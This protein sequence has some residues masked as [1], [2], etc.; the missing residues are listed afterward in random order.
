MT[1][2]EYFSILPDQYFSERNLSSRQQ[3]LCRATRLGWNR[4]TQI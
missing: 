3:P 2:V 1:F 4:E